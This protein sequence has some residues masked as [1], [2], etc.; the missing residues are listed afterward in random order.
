M[1]C[2]AFPLTPALSRWARENRALSLARTCNGVCRTVTQKNSD[3]RRL[4]PSPS[5]RGIKGE[6]EA[7]KSDGAHE[8]QPTNLRL[9]LLCLVA[10]VLSISSPSPAAEPVDA[11]T[12]QRVFDEV[13]TPFWAPFPWDSLRRLD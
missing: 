6:G 2:D 8:F 9:W 3:V 7:L 11:A 4:S 10:F 5:G 12:M 13:K 1:K